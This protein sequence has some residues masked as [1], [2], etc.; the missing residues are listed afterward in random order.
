MG[1][2]YR[3]GSNT[4]VVS[5]IENEHRGYFYAPGTQTAIMAGGTYRPILQSC[6]LAPSRRASNIT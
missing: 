3:R 1:T 5:E 2:S 6:Q 4:A